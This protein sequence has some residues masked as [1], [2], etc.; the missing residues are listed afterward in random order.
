MWKDLHAQGILP[1]NVVMLVELLRKPSDALDVKLDDLLSEVEVQQLVDADADADAD[2]VHTWAVG[3]E[4]QPRRNVEHGKLRELFVHLALLGFR[5]GELARAAVER[6]RPRRCGSDSDGA[7]GS[8]GHA[9]GDHRPGRREE[10][11][12]HTHA[13]PPAAPA[14][15]PP[16]AAYAH[17][18]RESPADAAASRLTRRSLCCRCGARLVRAAT[19]PAHTSPTASLRLQHVV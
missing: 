18:P 12:Q 19:S 2:A 1:R 9:R 13:R 17:A 7:R 5:R 11:R 4:P 15:G 16:G 3:A 14:A 6:R 10:A 8:R